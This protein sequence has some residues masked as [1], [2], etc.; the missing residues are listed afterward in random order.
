M[1]VATQDGGLGLDQGL[2]L[3]NAK[4]SDPELEKWID[5]VVKQNTNLNFIDRVARPEKYPT[6]PYGNGIATH[7]MSWGDIE[8]KPAVF[9]T[10]IFD[11]DTLSLKQLPIDQAFDHAAKTGEYLH[12]PNDEMADLFSREYKRHWRN[13]K[14][15]KGYDATH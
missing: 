12:F 15:P 5:S 13:G 9:P 1:P 6:L 7:L 4:S 14:G 3:S 10:I 8:G 11:P 2:G